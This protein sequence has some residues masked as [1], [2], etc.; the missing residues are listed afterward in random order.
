[1]KQVNV[2]TAMSEKPIFY[3]ACKLVGWHAFDILDLP[4]EF[5]KGMWL[6]L[7]RCCFELEVSSLGSGS[8]KEYRELNVSQFG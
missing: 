3:L 7:Y 2:R 1:M 5:S 8:D 6:L 4:Q